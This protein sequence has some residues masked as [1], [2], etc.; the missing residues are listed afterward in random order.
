MGVGQF[1]LESQIWLIIINCSV[2]LWG[3][4]EIVGGGVSKRNM[5]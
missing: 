4:G 5:H 3:E 1:K 2:V